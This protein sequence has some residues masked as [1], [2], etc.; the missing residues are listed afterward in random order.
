ME[1]ED[2]LLIYLDVLGFENYINYTVDSRLEAGQKVQN[3][4]RY[5]KMLRNFVDNERIKISESKKITCFSDLIIISIDTSEIEYFAHE[6]MDLMYLMYNSIVHGFLIRGA[7]VYGKLIHNDNQIFGPSLIKGYKWERDISK[8]PRIIIEES[9]VKDITE[10]HRNKYDPD[11]IKFKDCIV[12]D[13]DGFY[14][15]NYFEDVRET[16]DNLG[17]YIKFIKS[18]T[19]LLYEIAENPILEEKYSWLNT[20]F[21]N[22]I[23]EDKFI[24]Y[25]FGKKTLTK[26][27]LEVFRGYLT[28]FDEETYKNKL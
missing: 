9:I 8:Y 5:L 11:F 6:I 13:K 22:M 18:F 25:S 19:D 20:R 10:F 26:W 1:Y 4:Q 21:I 28:E 12:R 7:I 27:E 14:Y 2:R 23:E 17:Q 3:V 24:N 16:V 15:L